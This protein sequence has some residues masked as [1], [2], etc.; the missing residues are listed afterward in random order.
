MFPAH[1]LNYKRCG[2]FSVAYSHT[3]NSQE[4]W[5]MENHF[6][7]RLHLPAWFE[8]AFVVV[9]VG[10]RDLFVKFSYCCM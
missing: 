7:W 4:V 1:P 2:K 8:F 5:F 9:F 10:F 3:G 6:F